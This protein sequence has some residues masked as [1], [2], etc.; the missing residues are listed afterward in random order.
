VLTLFFPVIEKMTILFNHV[1]VNTPLQ[2]RLDCVLEWTF[3]F[4][5]IPS[6]YLLKMITGG[7]GQIV[8]D[9]E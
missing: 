5:C 9:Y 7:Y 4:E 2:Y 8:L 6:G 1:N 3:N